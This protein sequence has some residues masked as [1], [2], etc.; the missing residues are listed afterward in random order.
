MTLTQRTFFNAKLTAA[1]ILAASLLAAGA[2]AQV[3]KASFTTAPGA[4][5]IAINPATNMV[6]VASGTNNVATVI[7]GSTFATTTVKVGA[8]AVDIS[9][10]TSTN[11]IFV[12][13][14]T[15]STITEIDGATNATT[16]IALNG[17]PTCIAVDSVTHKIYA[18]TDTFKGSY[19][20]G[21][22]EVV[23]EA[24]GAVS[25]VDKGNE[26]VGVAI[27]PVT[28]KI[29]VVNSYLFASSLTV[30]DGADNSNSYVADVTGN[31]TQALAIDT[32]ADKLFLAGHE[33]QG[34]TYIDGGTG[35][36]SMVGPAED[37]NAIAANSTTHTAYACSGQDVAA[38]SEATGNSVT[39]TLPLNDALDPVPLVD[40]A[41]N[42]VFV[43]TFSTPGQ[44]AMIDASTNIP[45]SIAVGP[46]VFAM[47]ENPTTGILFLLSGDAAGT[48]TVVDGRSDSFGPV[49]T[50]QPES[51]TAAL[52]SPVALDAFAGAGA[53]SSP[54]YQ[55]SFDGVPL[56]DGAGVTGSSSPTL[57]L[58]SVSDA[59]A[60]TYTCA[61]SGSV[62]S[63][64][65]S[66]ATL[67]VD[68]SAAPGRLIN[69][70][71]RSSLGSVGNGA[72]TPIIAGFVVAGSGSKDVVLRG[73]GP[74]LAEFS[75]GDAVSAVS[76]SLF[77]SANPAN[78]ITTDAAWG[79]PPT[80]P[81]GPW[82]GRAT[83]VDASVADFNQVGAFVLVPGSADT[84]VKVTLPA[85]N[86]TVQLNAPAGAR[87]EALAEVYDGDAPGSA[88][89]LSNLSARS[90]V[91]ANPIIAGF[92]IAGPAAQTILIRASGPALVPFGVAGALSAMQL[93]V[94]DSH[95]NVV[96][97]N[98]AWQGNPS[99]AAVAAQVGAF[100][101]GNPASAD[102]A[103]LITL[104]P[105]SYT[106]QVTAINGQ[107]GTALAEVYGLP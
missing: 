91:G 41:A 55:W 73:V 87:G 71:S 36:Y 4:S 9:V 77:D 33:S 104:P 78:L 92:A 93:R 10:D 83:P 23:D 85:G 26:C 107:S 12:A 90:F 53:G 54:T 45:T 29:Y 24:T 34:I 1:G 80:V 13:N 6:Y 101:W 38:F 69:L 67:T 32:V 106:A 59:S 37:F 63:G 35:F 14:H 99:V 66:P 46:L 2:R 105:G 31:D 62:A 100:P 8:G 3:V 17:T 18:P 15:D 48:V 64:T 43:S 30:L 39:I 22:I 42:R 49:F 65:S 60:G 16:T 52:G 86:Y 28:N 94:F 11:K 96:A 79:T 5:A 21:A 72:Q 20:Y 74:T 102:C 76:L 50:S 68:D 88:S 7:N 84:A 27:N 98:S 44:L 95:Q 19:S 75:V 56:S 40:E 51:V 81:K 57:F 70:S 82:A 61:V 25:D 97:T 103:L 58:S 47:V 89:Q